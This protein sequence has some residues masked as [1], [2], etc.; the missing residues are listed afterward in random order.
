[1]GGNPLRKAAGLDGLKVHELRLC[2]AVGGRWSHIREV[3]V[4]AGHSSV[5][6]TLDNYGT[7]TR[8]GPTSSRSVDTCLAQRQRSKRHEAR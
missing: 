8:T 2:G 4:R 5:A 7:F 3:S 6:F 1:M